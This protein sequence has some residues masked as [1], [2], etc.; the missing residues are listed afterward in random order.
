MDDVEAVRDMAVDA[1]RRVL[2]KIHFQFDVHSLK[3]SPPRYL[4]NAPP[5]RLHLLD[6]ER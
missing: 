4:I 5:S 1:S 6:F 3:K 2:K